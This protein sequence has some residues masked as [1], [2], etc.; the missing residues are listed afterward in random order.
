MDNRFNQLILNKILKNLDLY[1]IKSCSLVNK[2]FN[3]MFNVDILWHSLFTTHY[4]EPID[5][6][7]K[8]FGTDSYKDTYKKYVLL[9]YLKKTLKLSHS[10]IKLVSLQCLDLSE[11]AL[12]SIP[13]EIGNLASLRDLVLCNNSLISIPEKIKSLP[14]LAIYQ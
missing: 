11:N 8:V 7:K 3:K 5:E 6:F 1:S 10:I 4:N 9:K 14:N 12:T 2:Q 13:A